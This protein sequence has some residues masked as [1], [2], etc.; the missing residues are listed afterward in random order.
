[1]IDRQNGNVR[2]N[3]LGDGCGLTEQQ[4]GKTKKKKQQFSGTNGNAWG[5]MQG[6][7]WELCSYSDLDLNM[8]VTPVKSTVMCEGRNMEDSLKA[9]DGF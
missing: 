2:M 7:R 4:T 6:Q 1:M 8:S 3:S 5:L 9:F